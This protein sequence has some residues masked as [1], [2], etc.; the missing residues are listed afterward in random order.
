MSHNDIDNRKSLKLAI[1]ILN[2]WGCTEKQKQNI[3]NISVIESSS[4]SL[5]Q[6]QLHRVSYIA[7]I[8]ASLRTLF[9][10]DLNVYSFMR[11]KNQNSFFKGKTPISLIESGSF[12]SLK[13]INEYLLAKVNE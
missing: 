7:N 5:T 4:V 9:N 1:N 8:H 3:L 6:Q 10:N 13:Q 2:R 12:E 11:L